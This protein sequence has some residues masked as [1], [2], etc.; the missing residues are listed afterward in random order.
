M[1]PWRKEHP[2]NGMRLVSP[3]RGETWKQGMAKPKA[4]REEVLPGSHDR[5]KEGGTM[6]H[7]ESDQF[8]VLGG[9]ESRLQGEGIDGIRS[10]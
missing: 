7:G 10:L 2:C 9:R 6:V 3:T 1:G 4:R 5:P 8:I